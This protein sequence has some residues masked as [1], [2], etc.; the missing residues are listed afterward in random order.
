MFSVWYFSLHASFYILF[1][2]WTWSFSM[3][4]F[5]MT[6][7]SYYDV[8]H[9]S[10]DLNENC[11][12]YVKL[13]IKD[14]LF[15]RIFWFS[16]YLLRKLRLIRKITSIVQLPYTSPLSSLSRPL[17]WVLL[18]THLPHTWGCFFKIKYFFKFLTKI[19]GR[20]R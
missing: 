20:S 16:E 1:F 9:F 6:L 19:L 15:V 4:F 11:R 10:T 7:P 2:V 14:I 3:P 13:K 5:I 17:G 18:G 8:T 12:T